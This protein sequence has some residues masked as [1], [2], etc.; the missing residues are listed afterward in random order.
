M[1]VFMSVSEET[2]VLIGTTSLVVQLVVLGLLAY[3]YSL[4]RKLKFRQHGTTMAA[5][6][7]LH[8][9]TIFALMIPSFVYA[10]IPEFIVPF[11]YEFISIIS[12]VHGITGAIAIVFGVGLVAAWRFNKDVKGCFPRKKFM[13]VAITVWVIALVLGIV[14][15]WLF[16][17]PFLVG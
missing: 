9:I 7:I 11:P 5:A 2:I 6:A 13:R 14:V 16:Y 4:K 17:L 12:I 15:Y 8:L 1:L 10:V 3:G